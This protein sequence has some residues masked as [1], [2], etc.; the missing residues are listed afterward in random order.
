MSGVN[1]I[2]RIAM[3]VVLDR[4]MSFSGRIARRRRHVSKDIVVE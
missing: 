2:L 4:V 3:R 1:G